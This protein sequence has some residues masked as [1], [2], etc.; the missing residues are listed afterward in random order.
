[1]VIKSIQVSFGKKHLKKTP[2]R[3]IFVWMI[4]SLLLLVVLVE[5]FVPSY[6]KVDAAKE[7]EIVIDD[8]SAFEPNGR[9]TSALRLYITADD[10]LFYLYYPSLHYKRYAPQL[11]SE[12]LSGKETTVKLKAVDGF[13]IWDTLR[14]RKRIVDLRSENSVYYELETE[15]AKLRQ[16]YIGVVCVGG[17]LLLL[18][19][20]D[21]V[22]ILL[23]Y[24]ELRLNSHTKV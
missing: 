21:S 24:G 10:Q 9:R 1:M 6:K 16:D 18:W 23:V 8:L 15:I 22:Y 14:G 13:T 11:E 5:I 2:R 7:Y 12:L 17:L 20:I 4:L 19:L 3:T